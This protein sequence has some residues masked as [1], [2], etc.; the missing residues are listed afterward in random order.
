MIC[1]SRPVSLAFVLY[2]AFFSG[3]SRMEFGQVLLHDDFCP[4]PWLPRIDW[5]IEADHRCLS[6]T[7]P[8]TWLVLCCD[9]TRG[10]GAMLMARL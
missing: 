9:R 5:E 3:Q 8:D 2:P 1:W 6:D 10:K 4:E 7:Y